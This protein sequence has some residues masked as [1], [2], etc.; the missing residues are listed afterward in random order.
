MFY[1]NGFTF[2]TEADWEKNK[3]QVLLYCS[4]GGW[5]HGNDVEQRMGLLMGAGQLPVGLVSCLAS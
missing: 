2:N 1:V 3:G 4:V 5:D